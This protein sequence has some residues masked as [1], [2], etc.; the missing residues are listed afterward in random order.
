MGRDNTP[1]ERRL[2]QLKRKQNQRASYDRILIISEGSKTEPLYFKE[3][4]KEFR[5]HTANIEIQPSDLGTDPLSVVR[6]AKQM[7][8][9]GDRHKGISPRAFEQVFAVFDRDDH[10]SFFDALTFAQS[11]DGKLR[12][13]DK[14]A[15]TFSA[16]A[17]IPSFELWLFLHYE[18]IKHPL[19]R[20]EVLRRLKQH[21]Q[22]Y[23]KGL[24]G[25][26]AITKNLMPTAMKRAQQLAMY[27]S[28]FNDKDPYTDISRLVALLMNLCPSNST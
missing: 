5:L 27:G 13:D 22:G 1:K 11:L 8:E 17:S 9:H 16:I 19:H 7:F 25:I 23:E 14:Q 12:N 6:Y 18:D 28:V 26:F 24:M 2:N 20:D 15:I 3:I 10:H 21:I 4:R